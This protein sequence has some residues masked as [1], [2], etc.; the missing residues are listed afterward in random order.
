MKDHNKRA[1]SIWSII[2]S[3]V[4]FKNKSVIDVGCGYCDI[5]WRMAKA[6]ASVSAV[7]KDPLA[8]KTCYE[9]K[10]HYKQ[11]SISVLGHYLEEFLPYITEPYDIAI[12]FSVLPYLSWNYDEALAILRDIVARE[13][14]IELQYAGDGPGR[15]EIQN[16]GDMRILLE[17]YYDN[18]TWLGA[19]S[20]KENQHMRSLWRCE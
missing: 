7:D 18:V 5:A 16:D 3:G 14:I 9:K 19:T 13:L 4:E 17:N 10:V 1:L 8:L 15:V 12:C 6:G 20:V 11:E 2:S